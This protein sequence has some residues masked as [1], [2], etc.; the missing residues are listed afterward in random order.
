[1]TKTCE[2]CQNTKPLHD[3]GRE[4]KYRRMA[5]EA[6]APE[7]FSGT[8]KPCT[9]KINKARAY[10]ENRDQVIETSKAWAEANPER[11]RE[12][13][14]NYARKMRWGKFGCTPEQ[15]EA[16]IERAGGRCEACRDELS[17]AV[18]FTI[19]HCHDSMAPRGVLCAPCN[20]ADGFLKSDPERAERLA[21]YLR[22]TSL[23]E[24]AVPIPAS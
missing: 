17:D 7:C 14:R 24:A 15:A 5:V 9:A 21:M 4:R 1:M 19:D 10:Q 20:K 2:N 16:M 23:L 22:R 8:C 6:L 3:F 13:R 18:G 12:H 11:A